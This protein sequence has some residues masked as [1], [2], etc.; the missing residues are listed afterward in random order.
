MQ[1]K[2]LFKAAQHLLFKTKRGN[3]R[4]VRDSNA[5]WL[6]VARKSSR[7][8]N[9]LLFGSK[10]TGSGLSQSEHIRCFGDEATE[11]GTR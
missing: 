7:N 3:E 5:V 10:W 6:R 8:E 11:A 9:V 1:R 4:E 2:L